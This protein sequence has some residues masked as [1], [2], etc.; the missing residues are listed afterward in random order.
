MD[1]DT[2]G[3]AA[4]ACRARYHDPSDGEFISRD[5]AGLW[6]TGG[7]RAIRWT[8]R[9]TSSWPRRPLR[10]RR[11][12]MSGGLGLGKPKVK[13]GTANYRASWAFPSEP[14]VAFPA[15]R[16]FWTCR[17]HR[18]WHWWARWWRCEFDR[19]GRLGRG[20][21]E[22]R[23]LR[24]SAARRRPRRWRDPARPRAR[25]TAWPRRGDRWWRTRWPGRSGS[26]N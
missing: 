8:T 11:F 4:E 20:G 2:Q 16:R 19:W 25:G 14:S 13:P 22:D 15:G 6:G 21:A 23:G 10:P 3:D 5:P 17:G 1:V 24:S 7:T 18:S 26:G 12:P 9:R